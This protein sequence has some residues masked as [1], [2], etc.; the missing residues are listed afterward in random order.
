[1]DGLKR[2]QTHS[3][4][5]IPPFQQWSRGTSCLNGEGRPEKDERSPGGQTLHVPRQV[6]SY[7][8]KYHWESTR[9]IPTEN[10]ST[11]TSGS[12]K[13]ICPRHR[14]TQTGLRQTTTRHS[15]SYTHVSS[16]RQCVGLALPRKPEVDT[17]NGREPVR[18]TDIHGT[19]A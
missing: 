16:W 8:T 17:Y 14:A 18:P 11:N 6:Q 4:F 12:T 15:F 3:M 7:A 9:R 10:A 1:M 2:H 19:P 5:A 13:T